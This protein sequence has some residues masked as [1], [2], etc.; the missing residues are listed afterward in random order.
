MRGELPTLLAHFGAQ[1][2]PAV[3]V[4]SVTRRR[5]KVPD[6]FQR[7]LIHTPET[8]HLRALEP[9]CGHRRA[10]ARDKPPA[11]TYGDILIEVRP[12]LVM[13]FRAL[14][15]RDALFDI[16]FFD[17]PHLIRKKAWRQLSDRYLHFGHW[18]TRAE[19]EGA[20][21][22]VNAEF[23]RVTRPAATLHVKIIDGPDRRVTKLA[24]L[25]RLTMWE[26]MDV[27]FRPSPIPW[28]KCRT[29]TAVMRRRD[30]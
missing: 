5:T 4:L 28:S 3:S 23:H 2:A 16:V 1:V 19:W 13:D 6:A 9:C 18:Q 15:F 22:A 21:D 17:P 29:V 8:E 12:E 10:W 24:D 20:L 25:E 11:T 27:K 7:M 14:P 26:P 30:P